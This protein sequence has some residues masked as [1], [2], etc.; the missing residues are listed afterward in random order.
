MKLVDLDKLLPAD[1]PQGERVLWHGRPEWARLA[2]TAYRADYVAAY[3]IALAIWNAASAAT[4]GDTLAVAAAVARTAALGSMGIGLLCLLAWLSAH[5]T[6]YVITSRRIVMKVGVALPIFFNIP[7]SQIQSAALRTYRDSAGDIPL[8][9]AAGRRIAWLHLWPH[10]RPLH[11]ANPQPTLRSIAQAP[12]VATVLRNAMIAEAQA[13][14]GAVS[15]TT[16]AATS[17]IGE[18]GQFPNGAVAA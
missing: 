16:Q 11:I 5:T 17:A 7:Y 3:F 13:R 2:R 10:A 9:L 14:L 6:L 15:A 8:A 12:E 1:I 4:E 18:Q